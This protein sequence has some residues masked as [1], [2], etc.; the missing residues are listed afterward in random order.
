[1]LNKWL[2]NFDNKLTH[3]FLIK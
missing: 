3:K 1:M 2:T